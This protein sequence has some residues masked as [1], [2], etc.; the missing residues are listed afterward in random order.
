[1]LEK[2][3]G[4]HGYSG[5]PMKEYLQKEHGWEFESVKRTELHTFKVMPRRWVVE[6][7]IGWLMNYRRLCRNYEY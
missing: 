5:Q 4:R 3:V 7:T 1:M 6:R 2:S